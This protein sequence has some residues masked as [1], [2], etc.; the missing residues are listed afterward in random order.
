MKLNEYGIFEYPKNPDSLDALIVERRE[1]KMVLLKRPVKWP[2]SPSALLFPTPG[3]GRG[4][5]PGSGFLKSGGLSYT[6]SF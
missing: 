6:S 3:P 2:P 1:K 4:R 5:R